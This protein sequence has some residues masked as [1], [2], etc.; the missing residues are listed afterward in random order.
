MVVGLSEGFEAGV[1]WEYEAR[2]SGVGYI[3][4]AAGGTPG[5]MLVCLGSN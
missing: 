4:E 2:G 1:V 3:S 5:H